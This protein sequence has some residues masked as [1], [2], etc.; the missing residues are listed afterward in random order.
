MSNHSQRDRVLIA[1]RILAALIVP[2]LLAAFIILYLFA[3]D[4]DRLFAWP[5][6]PSMSAMMLG[7]TYLGGAYFFAR[8]VSARQWHT[9]KL[10]F[11]PVTAFAGIL[12][13]TT[14]LYWER[15]SHGLFAFTLW[16]FLYF[17]LPVIIPIIW[18]LN[19]RA[20]QADDDLREP[21]LS[22]SLSLAFATV[23]LVMLAASLTF[24]LVPDM[25]TPAWLWTLSPL[26]VRILSAMFALPGLVQLGIAVDRR[27]SSARILLQAQGL[28]IVL[29][30]AAMIL[31]RQDIFWDQWQCWLFIAG[32]LLV[33][34]LI[35]WA[36]V[37]S[38][39]LL[40]QA[41]V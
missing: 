17:T 20:N 18:Y 38:R 6:K 27:W 12:G 26:T 37:A 10:G 39:K 2:I 4:T 24:L 8:V 33:L 1:A 16:A 36:V 30:L 21:Q 40:L 25:M 32:L 3:N 13:L 19:R 7:A 22:R 41:S 15:F 11:L 28:S 9:V 35:G 29:I 34:L 23:G 5:I 14:A 31:A